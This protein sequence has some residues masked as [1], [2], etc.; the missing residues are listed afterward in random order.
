MDRSKTGKLLDKEGKLQ[1]KN[2]SVTFFA[3]LLLIIFK[4]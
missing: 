3:K 4:I 1:T 2:F